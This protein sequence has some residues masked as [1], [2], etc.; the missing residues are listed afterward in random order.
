MMVL[1]NLEYEVEDSASSH[2]YFSEYDS[3]NEYFSSEEEIQCIPDPDWNQLKG[4][5]DHRFPVKSLLRAIKRVREG[6]LE[7]R[8]LKIERLERQ[9]E[10]EKQK[11]LENEKRLK[12]LEKIKYLDDVDSDD[13]EIYIL[14]TNELT[15]PIRESL[16]SGLRRGVVCRSEYDDR[17]SVAR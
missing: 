16:N 5:E 14:P 10:E 12:E 3:E 1:K 2:E 7:E 8:R 13:E 17:T 9:E 15:R 6:E 11:E 4:I